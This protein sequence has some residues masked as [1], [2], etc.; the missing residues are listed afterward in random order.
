M[1]IIKKMLIGCCLGMLMLSAG[2][3]SDD[4][5]P[6]TVQKSTPV[7]AIVAAG[8][9]TT[10][11]LVEAKA[12]N[13]E[14]VA[15]SIPNG[16]A[17]TPPAGKP[18]TVAPTIVVSTPANGTTS[19]IS[20]VTTGGTTFTL[21]SA[22]GAVDISIPG[23]TSFTV[24]GVGATVIIPVGDATGLTDGAANVPVMQYKADGTEIPLLGTYN[25]ALKIVTVNTKVTNF[26]LFVIK[27]VWSNPSGAT[28][29]STSGTTL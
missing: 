24:G 27:P 7:P 28:G 15:V 20:P 3:G 14:V 13:S 26:C 1:K 8:V 6:T 10:T 18:F 4:P 25:A 12:A 19:G 17:I 9:A 11:Q 23:V 21:T 16:V 29:G 5:A 2:C 22:K